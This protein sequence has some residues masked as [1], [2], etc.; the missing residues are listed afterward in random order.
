MYFAVKVIYSHIVSQS[1]SQDEGKT[2]QDYE[3]KQRQSATA[4]T[5]RIENRDRNICFRIYAQNALI[6]YTDVVTLTSNHTK[7]NLQ[8]L[9]NSNSPTLAIQFNTT[10]T[11]LVIFVHFCNFSFCQRQIT[12]IAYF[13][14]LTI[15]VLSG[16]N[17][18]CLPN[19]IC[20]TYRENLLNFWNFISLIQFVYS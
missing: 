5:Q 9:Q 13:F 10:S 3:Y 19:L 18:I 4:D 11:T 15:F 7:Y 16:Y 8:I 14:L 20:K 1:Q 6:Y 17:N 2:R 12:H